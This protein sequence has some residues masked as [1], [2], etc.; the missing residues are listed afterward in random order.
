MIYIVKNTLAL[1]IDKNLEISF[2]F[3][4]KD[5]CLKDLKHCLKDHYIE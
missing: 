4:L 5:K 2:V 1:Q 3:L